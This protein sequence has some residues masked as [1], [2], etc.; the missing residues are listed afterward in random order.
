MK[1]IARILLCFMIFLLVGCENKEVLSQQENLINNYFTYLK[2]N[3]LEEIS[4]ISSDTVL[5][6]FLEDIN[7]EIEYYN[8]V[9]YFGEDFVKSAKNYYNYLAEYYID[10][11]KIKEIKKEDKDKYEAYVDVMVRD[12][13]TLIA[14]AYNLDE[15]ADSYME[16]SSAEIENILK[17]E[18]EDAARHSVYK[19]V[20]QMSFAILSNN[21]KSIEP[22]KVT[23]RM[24]LS[25]E[26]DNWKILYFT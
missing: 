10:S 15:L 24:V 5:V 11:Y 7:E 8:D 19:A 26:N 1:N 6:S 13:S 14:G 16:R 3:N 9:E 25:K 2:E 12:Y 20:A 17:T 23:I 4:K 22:E 21:V 18:G